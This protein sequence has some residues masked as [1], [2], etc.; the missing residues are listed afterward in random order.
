MKL[1]LPLLSLLLMAA[2]APSGMHATVIEEGEGFEMNTLSPHLPLALESSDQSVSEVKHVADNKAS[3]AL[4]H[5]EDLKPFSVIDWIEE[6]IKALFG[7]EPRAELAVP[8]VAEPQPLPEPQPVPTPPEKEGVGDQSQDLPLPEDE[9]SKYQQTKGNPSKGGDPSDPLPGSRPQDFSLMG[10]VTPTI[11][12]QPTLQDDQM[13]S[14]QARVPLK[15]AKGVELMRVC[16]KTRSICAMEGSCRVTQNGK[17][18]SFNTLVGG[19]FFELHSNE[20]FFGYGVSNICLDPFHTVA[21][22]PSF[23]KAGSV[24]FI[25]ALVGMALP[26]GG[27]HRGFFVVRDRGGHILG[28][29]RFDFF[30]GPMHWDDPKNPFFQARL[31]DKKTKLQYYRVKNETAEKILRDRRFPSYPR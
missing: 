8:P 4:P 17:V 9:D 5:E 23:H 3:S 2:C 26:S 11:Y 19:T 31:N 24:I 22:D 14:A 13:C 12:F 16:Q 30:S 29:H 21:A 15:G 27:K 28:A 10:H 6:K 7:P 20:C 25:P 1:F 18:R